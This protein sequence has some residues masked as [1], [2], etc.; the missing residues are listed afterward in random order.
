MEDGRL[1]PPPAACPDGWG[2]VPGLGSLPDALLQQ[3]SIQQAKQPQIR[4]NIIMKTYFPEGPEIIDLGGVWTAPGAIQTPTS[5]IAG[6][7]KICFHD[8]LDTKLGL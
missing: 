6:F 3:R 4:I 7:R 1:E 8:Y 5:M 2:S